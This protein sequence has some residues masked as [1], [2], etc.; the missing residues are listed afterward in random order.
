MCFGA[1]TSKSWYENGAV[2]KADTLD[3]LSEKIGLTENKLEAT[4]KKFNIFAE[5]GR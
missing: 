4:V 2:F 3:E 1:T 5:A